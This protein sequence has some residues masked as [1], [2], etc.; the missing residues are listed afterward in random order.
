M[1]TPLS[2]TEEAENCT[3]AGGSVR[4]VEE[5]TPD[6]ITADDWH[7]IDHERVLD[8]LH[9]RKDGLS[10]DD[11]A[12]R[13][14][15]FGPNRIPEAARRSAVERLLL[16]FHNTLI[17]ILI[18]AAII[19]AV[20][21]QLT[22][23]AVIAG[24]VVLNAIIGFIQEGRAE[25]SLDAIR[26]MI[27]PQAS[28][29]RNGQRVTI[30]ADQIVPGDIVLFE[31]GDRVPAD[32]RLV[33]T[34]SVRIDE[35]ALTGESVAV[36][37]ATAPVAKDTVLGDRSSMAYSGTHVV[38]GR[39]T[40][41]VIGTGS[42][43]ELGRI[44][45]LISGIGIPT[46]RFTQ[47]IGVF[48]RAITALT[49]IISI[50][51]FAF[52]VLVR[53]YGLQ[54]A[55]MVMVGLAV[56]AIPEGLPAVMTIALAIGVQRMAARNAVIRK[57]PAVETLGSV[58]VVCSDKTG[59][60][61]RNEMTARRVVTASRSYEVAGTGYEPDGTIVAD[62]GQIDPGKDRALAELL[63]TAAL[64]NDAAISESE[65][66]WRVSGDPMEGALVSLAMKAGIDVDQLRQQYRRCD[67]IPFDAEHR[68]MATLHRTDDDKTHVLIKGAP[69]RLIAMCRDQRGARGVVPI[70][71]PHWRQQ[72][73][74]LAA[75]GYRTLAFAALSATRG[76]QD[77]TLSDVD[78]D[79]V[80][81]GVVGFIDPPRD[82]AIDA[83]AECRAA[84]IRVIM[85]TGD[86]AATAREI[87]R[88]LGLAEDP[89]V[90]AGTDVEK[91]DETGLQRAAL[92][93]DV[94][95]RTAPE[96][97][98]RL[99]E[100]LQADGHVVAMTGDGVNDAPALKRA[101][102]GIAMGRKGTEVA[103]D[104]AEMVL[105]DDNFASIVAAIREG[106]TVYDN[107]LKVVALTLPTNG[108]EAFTILTAVAFGLTLPMTAVQ[109]L[110]VNM[111]T[112]VALDLALAFEPTEPGT[113]RRRP[114]PTDEPILSSYLLWR[115]I[116]VT[117]LMVAG[118]FGLYYWSE[119]RGLST[120][121]GRTIVVNAI[122]VM[123]LFYLFSV[124]N[125]H[126]TSLTWRGFLATPAV[127]LGVVA[128]IGG[129]L[130]FTYLPFMQVAFGTQA[131]GLIESLAV[132]GTG[133]TLLLLVEV[134]K[135]ARLRYLGRRRS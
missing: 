5:L 100:A 115:T 32:V 116:Y 75:N 12:H 87:A 22:D 48:G 66:E 34:R 18:A 20:L 46:T 54:D 37:K 56:A 50:A 122:V 98:L 53:G 10:P 110:W 90:L 26:R 82:E 71:R 129:Q 121:A 79:S 44:G 2:P 17:Y 119:S 27:T 125:I 64:C 106:R 131:L 16:Q 68:F 108:G 109:I 84:G 95:A 63:R 77:L 128:V 28:L 39:G 92:E 80:F 73:D 14:R 43:T 13:Y 1:T 24:V 103:K 99:V 57:L 130:A 31:P 118:A 112:T 133:I 59:T 81:L 36:D 96:H 111:I 21:G 33:D 117:L 74:D 60:L 127:R 132:I 11:A 85:I 45:A 83:I 102:V 35:A 15:T 105:V 52:A 9:A 104:A 97:K 135:Q 126:H 91:L 25:R 123:E 47:K 72:V 58:T 113:M 55:F 7:A 40:G 3:E 93:T 29:L 38:A 107:L 42:Q 6:R 86:H 30:P 88:Q 69:E 4:G 62:D 101:D 61:T 41:V 120:E 114:R 70:D 51:V 134:E 76:D 94:F 19:S 8:A 67:E 49:L 65:A 23:A 89:K 78:A 124:R